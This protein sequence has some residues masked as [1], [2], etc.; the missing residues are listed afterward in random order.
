MLVR[1]LLHAFPFRPDTIRFLTLAGNHAEE[2]KLGADHGTEDVTSRP[3]GENPIP[4]L[5]ITGFLGAGKT[6]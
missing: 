2:A 6:T 5:I 1:V 4:V 3:K